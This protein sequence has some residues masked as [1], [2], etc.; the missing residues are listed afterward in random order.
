MKE[1]AWRFECV[2]IG[3]GETPEEAWEEWLFDVYANHKPRNT[4]PA[5]RAP[6]QD[7]D[8]DE[9]DSGKRPNPMTADRLTRLR[10]V[11]AEVLAAGDGGDNTMPLDA[12]RQLAER[13][14]PEI[15]VERLADSPVSDNARKRLG[16]V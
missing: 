5:V 1:K 12:A 10:E 4:P 2:P 14:D 11:Y 9:D 7:L 13:E 3:F 8:D 16:A 6:E 15:I